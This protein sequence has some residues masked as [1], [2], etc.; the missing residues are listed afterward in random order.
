MDRVPGF[1]PLRKI[2]DMA[3]LISEVT[4]E[5]TAS[6][7]DAL[8]RERRHPGRTV[9]EEFR[10]RGGPRYQWGPHL[11]AFYSSTNAFLY[12]LAVW[13]RNL[14]KA[15]MRR[16][17]TRHMARQGRPLDVLGIGDGLGFDCLH[18]SHKKHHVTYFEL[19]GTSEQFARMLFGRTGHDIPIL[20]DPASIPRESFDAIICFDVLEHVPD[21]ISMV[22]TLAS[23]L[24][25]GG[26]IYVSAPFYM[27]LPWYPTH[28][29]GNRRFS[30]S[31]NLYRQA[32]LQLIAGRLT[33][34]PIVL[35]KPGPTPPPPERATIG[36]RLTGA[37]QALGRVAA[38]PFVPVHFLRWMGNTRY[39]QRASADRPKL[40]NGADLP[41]E[42]RP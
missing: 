30:G 4:G 21:P 23:Y 13:N 15:T 26:H 6:V 11:E 37:I 29:R 17:T 34:Y 33:W 39:K 22:N 18:L 8:E 16:W 40:E 32:G 12:E 41:Q 42:A 25:P 36:L 9:A 3:S 24:R 27:I 5:A 14:L 1:D 28:L 19:P 7:I 10:K 20:T 2:E 38:W 31:L 35:R